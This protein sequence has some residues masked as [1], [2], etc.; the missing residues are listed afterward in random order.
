MNSYIS[1]ALTTKL[2]RI[3]PHDKVLPYVH[4]FLNYT[5]RSTWQSELV[6]Y[7]QN[8]YRSTGI[9]LVS[10]TDLPNARPPHIRYTVG[11]RSLVNWFELY[12]IP[13]E[14]YVTVDSGG[15]Q[16]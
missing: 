10:K 4:H 12:I 6:L 9:T 13:C 16:W 3:V 8:T 1:L 14:G 2:L 5:Y 11:T 7:L 15:G